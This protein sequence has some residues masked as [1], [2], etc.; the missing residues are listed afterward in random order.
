LR[1]CT[2][3]LA[4]SLEVVLVCCHVRAD[5]PASAQKG[6]IE[7]SPRFFGRM[8][9][10]WVQ[11]TQATAQPKRQAPTTSPAAP[12]TSPAAP[13]TSP[14]VQATSPPVPAASPPAP[15]EGISTTPSQPPAATPPASA[16]AT[17]GAA[18]PSAG[19]TTPTQPSSAEPSTAASESTTSLQEQLRGIGG[20]IEPQMIGDMSPLT[21]MQRAVA[22]QPLQTLPSPFPPGKLPKPPPARAASSLAPSTRGFK[23]ADN[24]SP[25]PQDRVYFTF[26]YFNNL[27]SAQNRQLKSPLTNMQA[28]RYVFGL[29]KTFDEGRGSIGVQLPLDSLSADSAIPGTSAKSGGTSTSLNDLTIIGKYILKRNPETGNLI[30]AGLAVTPTTGPSTFAGAGYVAAVHDTTVQPFIGYLWRR[31]DF[32]LHG[33]TALDVPTSIRDVTMV[34]NDVGIGY[35]VYR[36][37]DPVGVLTALVPTFEV[38]V[39]D[40]LTHGDFNNPLDL[41]GTADIVDLTYG[42]NA[43]LGPNSVFTFGVVTPVTGPHPFSYELLV[44]LNF[45]FGR[46]RGPRAP[47]PITGG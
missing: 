28:Y 18:Q 45:R 27:N 23:I 35:Y 11:R 39:N 33:F 25:L 3:L 46:S 42:I 24:Q 1:P 26:D 13:P 7:R 34:Y 10:R 43:L 14:P 12:A 37:R 41:T 38:H 4:L 30:S 22:A 17:A 9:D 2:L 19:A 32:F 15:T 36:N 21:V 29:E 6:S 40:P 5:E 16:P 8:R 44:L 47:L 20:D 31:G